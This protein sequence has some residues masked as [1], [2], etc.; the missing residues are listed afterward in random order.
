MRGSTCPRTSCSGQATVE[1]AFLIPVLFT[2]VLMLVQP[3]IVLYDRM[4]MQAAAS[5]ACRMMSTSTGAYGMGEESHEAIVKRHL[6]AV[7]QQELFHVHDG[8][9]SWQ[10]E[11][12]GDESSGQVEARIS[13]RIRLLPLI[14]AACRFTGIADDAGCMTI[15]V[16]QRARTQPQWALDAGSGP[17]GW[18]YERG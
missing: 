8:G 17:S 9:C 15:E 18:V 2:V 11:L 7:P 3:G 5:D 6:G 12:S 16:V 1:A 13:N 4:V 14:D 10:V